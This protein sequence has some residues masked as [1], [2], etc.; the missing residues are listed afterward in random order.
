AVERA[1]C[2][3]QEIVSGVSHPAGLQSPCVDVPLPVGT[4]GLWVGGRG[5][6]IVV[7]RRRVLVFVVVHV[8]AR[9]IGAVAHGGHQILDQRRRRRSVTRGDLVAVDAKRDLDTVSLGQRDANMHLASG[10]GVVV[11][12]KVG[13]AA[14]VL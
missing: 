14:G 1:A 6:I 3:V 8:Y 11:S 4:A 5:I 7:V 13:V 9:E 2:R 10:N 12:S